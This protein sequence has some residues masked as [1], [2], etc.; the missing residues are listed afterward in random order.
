MWHPEREDSFCELQLA[1]A[2]RLLMGKISN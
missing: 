2:E 1:R